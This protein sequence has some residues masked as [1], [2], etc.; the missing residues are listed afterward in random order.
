MKKVVVISLFIFSLSI[1][2]N[3]QDSINVS[4]TVNWQNDFNKA[5]STAKLEEKPLL[6]FF[7]G[8]DWCSPCKML[9]ADFF[10]SEKFNEFAKKEF[11]LYEADFPRNKD[12]V[13]DLQ[14]EA[15]N[16][17]KIKYKV[18]SYP[19]VIIVDPNGKILAKRK[20]YNLMRDTSYYFD[21]V[22]S[23]LK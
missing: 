17:L 14:I 19:T 21:F 8:S 9:V 5:K 4:H 1:G 6:I 18:N 23:V 10:E 22:E 20:G 15:N 2:V 13:T 12:L 16:K 3:A 11:I 7:T